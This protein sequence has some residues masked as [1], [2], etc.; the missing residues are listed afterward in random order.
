MGYPASSF[1]QIWR[2]FDKLANG[3]ILSLELAFIAILIG[4]GI[5]LVLAVIY[6]SSGRIVRTIISAYVEFIRDVPLP[7]LV[8]LVFYGPPTVVKYRLRRADVVH[9]DAIGLLRRLPRRSVPLRS[10]RRARGGLDA[11][12][13]MGLTPW[14][15]L[16]L[17]APA[18]HDAD[19]L[20][21]A[22]RQ[23]HSSSRIPPSPRSIAGADLT[24][25]RS[26]STTGPSASSRST[27]LRP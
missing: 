25:A 19:H 22:V 13:A 24:W 5:G 16:L 7:L 27:R 8:Y 17:R 15:R 4:A 6:V 11:G 3:V 12:K 14:Q 21:G 20:A 2:N 23:L 10:R 26:R 1:N 9:R 18:H